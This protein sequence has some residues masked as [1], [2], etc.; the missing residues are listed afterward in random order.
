MKLKNLA[1]IFLLLILSAFT[2]NVKANDK[3]P[4][5]YVD[6][7]IN[8]APVNIS[9][10]VN[11][12]IADVRDVYSW[13][14]DLEW[15]V[16]LLNATSIT[17]GTFLNRG[18]TTRYPTFFI[19]YI[20]ND[21]GY[22]TVSSSL[23]GL[24]PT[25]AASGNGTLAVITFLVKSISECKLHLYDTTLVKMISLWETEA[26]PHVTQ[27][28][29]FNNKEGAEV[30]PVDWN[31]DD[32]ID[33]YVSSVSNS[34]ISNFEFSLSAKLIS[35]NVTC[36]DGTGF[37][38]VTIPKALLDA[39][40]LSKWQV[41]LNEADVTSTCTISNTTTHTFIYVPYSCSTHTIR[42]I[43]IEVVSE[44]TSLIP[45]TIL[46]ISAIA[47]IILARKVRKIKCRVY[48]SV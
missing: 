24:P 30:H 32:I 1:Y 28:G 39:N 27:D 2:M 22:L 21:E 12:S 33:Y 7:P 38:N 17:Q 9:F 48:T 31:N 16:S 3:T 35:F 18:N 20:H 37:C 4:K 11:I 42:I 13:E 8:A 29:Y 5:V 26:I 45:L 19:Q 10:T 41:L 40:P 14:F 43:G 25:D 23:R 15:D 36:S 6:P 46:V 47:I 34:T 44:F